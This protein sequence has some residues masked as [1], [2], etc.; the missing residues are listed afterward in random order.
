MFQWC[1][2]YRGFLISRKNDD[3][4]ADND[5]PMASSRPPGSQR[6]CLFALGADLAWRLVI[7]YAKNPC[8]NQGRMGARFKAHSQRFR[9]GNNKGG[10]K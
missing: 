6:N 8:Y 10:S 3:C 1:L 7:V 5:S 2:F 9:N 4:D